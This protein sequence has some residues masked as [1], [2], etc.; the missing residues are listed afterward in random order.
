MFLE[1]W[2]ILDY[3]NLRLK[4]EDSYLL[5]LLMQQ[6]ALVAINL[7]MLNECLG[8]GHI[9]RLEYSAKK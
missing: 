8:K 4:V 7:K 1:M 5:R 3:K 6:L 9:M 2:A